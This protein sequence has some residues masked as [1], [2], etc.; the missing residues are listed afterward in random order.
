MA[1]DMEYLKYKE[2]EDKTQ[3]FL[4]KFNDN[5]YE[6]TEDDLIYCLTDL[7]HFD[8]FCNY[9]NR[10]YAGSKKI[11]KTKA[12]KLIE[13]WLEVN[14]IDRNFIESIKAALKDYCSDTEYKKIEKYFV[15]TASTS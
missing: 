9:L 3:S 14:T 1:Y 8:L 6:P 11:L 5:S 4:L 2:Y 15:E 10:N 12:Y 13:D 7:K